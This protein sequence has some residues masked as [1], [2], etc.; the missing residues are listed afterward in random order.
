MTIYDDGPDPGETPGRGDGCLTD[1][2]GVGL[3]LLLCVVALLCYGTR[4]Y[5]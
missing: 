1:L 2:I 5:R 3:C 4:F